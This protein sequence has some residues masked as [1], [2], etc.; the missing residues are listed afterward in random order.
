MDFVFDMGEMSS[1]LTNDTANWVGWGSRKRGLST[2]SVN[3]TSCLAGQDLI[4]GAV[5]RV[6]MGGRKK[7]GG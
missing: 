2:F 4:S 5:H 3:P 1:S 7:V 6:V